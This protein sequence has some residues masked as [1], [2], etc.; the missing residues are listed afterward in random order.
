MRIHGL[1]E[2]I[3]TGS[4]KD[5]DAARKELADGIAAADE[6]FSVGDC[7]LHEELTLVDAVVAP[8]LWRLP[9]FGVKLPK[10]VKHVRDYEERM[11]ARESFRNSLTE[12]ESEMNAA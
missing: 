2:R 11:F 3:E 10:S 12:P 6:L 9:H 7:F 5:A 4:K 8:L 1:V